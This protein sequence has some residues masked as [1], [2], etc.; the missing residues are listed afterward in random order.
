MK[1]IQLAIMEFCTLLVITSPL[2][3]IANEVMQ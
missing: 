1:K 3:I 2:I